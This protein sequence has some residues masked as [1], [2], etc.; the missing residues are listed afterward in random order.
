MGMDSLPVVSYVMAIRN[1]VT[2]NVDWLKR[3]IDS[4]LN[5]DYAGVIELVVVD[6]CSTDKTYEWVEGYRKGLGLSGSRVFKSYRLKGRLGPYGAANF[7]MGVST[8]IYIAR[9]DGDDWSE[10][11]RTT[12]Q[13]NYLNSNESVVLVSS[14]FRVYNEATGEFGDG[15]AVGGRFLEDA[16]F[17]KNG[18]PLCHCT[19]MFRRSLL[20]ILVGY[21]TTYFY[22]SDYDFIWR[23]HCLGKVWV[24]DDVLYNYRVHRNRI[25]SV[26]WR[27]QSM[28]ANMIKN[29]ILRKIRKTE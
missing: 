5:Q 12:K 9:Q 6:D 28:Y 7:G 23:S 3:S 21:N 25:T 14:R 24:L 22:S 19:I 4:I 20:P 8:G 18:S 1:E 13:V 26:E 29:K 16:D 11:G 17:L 27:K 10:L 2:R 15:W